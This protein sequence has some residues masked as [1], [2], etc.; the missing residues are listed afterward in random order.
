MEIINK[1]ERPDLLWKGI[2]EDFI[3]EL[4]QFFYS[5]IE[6]ERDKSKKIE[7]LDKFLKQINPDSEEENRR[8][9]LLIKVPLKGGKEKWILL[10]IEVQGYEDPNFAR[11]M[12]TYF[13]RTYDRFNIDIETIDRKGTMR[14][15]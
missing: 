9:D 10:H 14:I 3:E 15:F 2:I 7:F 11:R 13:Y 12:F 6:E 8:A 5:E 4:L 1:Y